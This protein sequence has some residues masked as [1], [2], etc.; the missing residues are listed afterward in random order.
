MSFTNVKIAALK[1]KGKRYEIWEG[2]GFGIRVGTS[3]KR[4]WVGLYHFAGRPRRITYGSYPEM[5]LAAA[6][7]AD[8]TAK[9]KIKRGIDPGAELVAANEVD[10]QAETVADLS[11]EYLER[12]ARK[13]KRSAAQDER[14]LDREIIPQWGRRKAKEISARDVVLLLDRIED[15]GSPVMRNRTAS[16]LSK[17]FRF[18]VTR[19]IVGASPA[20][21]IE[22]LA[23]TSRTRI[24]SAAEIRLLW[25]GL[26]HANMDRRTALAIRFCLATGQRR[27]EVAGAARNEIIDA[28]AIWNL[29][30]H[31]TKNGRANSI[32]LNAL[33]M[34][35]VREADLLRVKPMPTRPKRKDRSAFD[36]TPSPWLFPSTQG[37]KPLD[38]AALTRALN[39]SREVLGIGDATIHDLRRTFATVLGEVETAP[40]VLRAL[41]NHTPQEITE[42]VYNLAE[43]LGPRRRAMQAWSDW[44]T[45]VITGAG[46]GA[47]GR[48]IC[49]PFLS[50]DPTP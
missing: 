27:G 45:C 3:G 46:E 19:G 35:I 5:S 33:A 44:L 43:N 12:H 50:C 10:R 7:V 25:H 1:P 28:E 18:G 21:G 9:E 34:Q 40:E 36:P 24:L 30:G 23:E 6:R 16:L 41:L 39:R 4:T 15:R 32:P 2:G 14:T 11:R 29:P 48:A 22:R 8:A 31:R 20:V 13:K 49:A 47:S 42:R 26:D 17:M 37:R 38:P